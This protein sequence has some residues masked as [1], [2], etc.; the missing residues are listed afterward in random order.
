MQMHVGYIIIEQEQQIDLVSFVKGI[1]VSSVR[2]VRDKGTHQNSLAAA[3]IF[4]SWLQPT[5]VGTAIHSSCM[6]QQYGCS[7][8]L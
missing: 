7:Q 3:S 6:Q 2:T 5:Y 4:S 8:W 1:I